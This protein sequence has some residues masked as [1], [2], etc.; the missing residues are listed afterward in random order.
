M[1]V[2]VVPWVVF[3][4]GCGARRSRWR[5]LHRCL[6]WNGRWRL[7]ASCNGLCYDVGGLWRWLGRWCLQLLVVDWD[8]WWCLL[9]HGLD[10]DATAAAA[11]L[12]DDPG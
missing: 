9:G 2:S 4:L 8:G 10:L 7:S 3:L 12:L 11:C 6:C 5:L 1:I